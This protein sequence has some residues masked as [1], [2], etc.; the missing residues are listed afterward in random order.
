MKVNFEGLTD[1]LNVISKDGAKM[2]KLFAAMP[3]EQAHE[4]APLQAEL[5]NAIN[6]VKNGDV[7]ALNNLSKK[8]S[9]ANTNK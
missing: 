6:A 5:N 2:N 1:A 7:S 8:Y 4:I 9:D 3:S